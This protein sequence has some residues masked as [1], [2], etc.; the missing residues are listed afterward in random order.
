[1]SSIPA[2][3]SA[4][5]PS[6]PIR[7]HDG[8]LVKQAV[9]KFDVVQA[10]AIDYFRHAKANTNTNTNTTNTNTDS[11]NDSIWRVEQKNNEGITVW[12]RIGLGESNQ[13]T[14]SNTDSQEKIRLLRTIITMNCNA[15]IVFGILKDPQ[16]T[17]K[18]HPSIDIAQPLYY[19]NESTRITYLTLKPQM[20]GVISARHSVE[21]VTWGKVT[22]TE[23]DNKEL[24]LLVSS[25]I[26]SELD[27]DPTNGL[28]T[29]SNENKKKIRSIN[30]LNAYIVL[31]IG[32][33]QCEIVWFLET[34]IKG[35]ISPSRSFAPMVAKNIETLKSLK[36]F[37]ERK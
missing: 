4:Y 37:C 22:S 5:G 16:Q 14:S 15:D 30:Y 25:S 36:T 35:W 32:P 10:L 1:M 13:I 2:S 24:S 18:W 34:D 31:P 7:S 26:P 17:V 21:V 8:A 3:A 12:S 20:G 27:Q 23:C 19:V 9:S 11:N 33:N 29:A 6:H 28:P